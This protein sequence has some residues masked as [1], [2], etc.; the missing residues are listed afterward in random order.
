MVLEALEQIRKAEEK[1]GDLKG[2]SKNEVRQYE[3]QKMKEIKEL[4][5]ASNQKVVAIST[6]LENIQ[7]EQLKKERELLVKE[8]EATEKRFQEKYQKNK[9]QMI[10]YITERVKKIYGSQ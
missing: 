2:I 7:T 6:D 9:N 1:V 10:D 5:A 4:Q 8:A 3:E